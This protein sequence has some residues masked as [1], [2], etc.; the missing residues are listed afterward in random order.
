MAL[1]RGHN[2]QGAYQKGGNRTGF[3]VGGRLENGGLVNYFFGEDGNKRLQLENFVQFLRDLHHEV[4]NFIDLCI[5]KSYFHFFL[6][7]CTHKIS[8]QLCR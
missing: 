6:L 1:M 5:I 8:T 3:K 7:Y 4:H 2:R